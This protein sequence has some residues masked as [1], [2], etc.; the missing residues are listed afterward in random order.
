MNQLTVA[1]K[2]LIYV[3]TWILGLLVMLLGAAYEIVALLWVGLG[4]VFVAGTWALFIR[5]P[6]CGHRLFRRR[7]SILYCP[8]H[9]P[10]CG[11]SLQDE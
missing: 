2:H 10:E 5:C 7:H 4:F 8:K 1:K 11:E 9:C 6:H 3:A